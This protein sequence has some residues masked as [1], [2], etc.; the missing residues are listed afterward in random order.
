MVMV[1]ASAGWRIVGDTTCTDD[2]RTRAEDVAAGTC[3]IR[4]G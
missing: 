2:V 4:A 3:T 1:A